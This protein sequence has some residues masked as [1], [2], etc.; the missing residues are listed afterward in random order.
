MARLADLILR[1]GYYDKEQPGIYT[2][3]LCADIR[4]AAD[5]GMVIV[6]D[7][8]ADLLYAD[9]QRQIHFPDDFPT[10]APPAPVLWIEAKSSVE[11]VPITDGVLIQAED[12]NPLQRNYLADKDEIGALG[13]RWSLVLSGFKLHD[14]HA[15]LKIVMQMLI[16]GHGQIVGRLYVPE[17][18]AG[19]E[20]ALHYGIA[21]LSPALLTIS[22]LHARNVQLAPLE[23]SEKLRKAYQRR[24][25]VEPLRFRTL[26][27]APLRQTLEREGRLGEQGLGKALHL[28]RGHFAH[29][30]EE[31]P[32]F[33]KYV[34]VFW[35]PLH[36]RGRAERGVVVGERRLDP[37]AKS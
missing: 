5:A 33:G 19:G 2:D 37:R 17:A 34:G 31:R 25:G 1:E 8:V 22:F 27:M 18:Y 35:H 30:S 7:D 13:A 9:P 24:H 20:A 23:A 6:A 32:L 3:N 26:V 21:L 4:T 12:L 28:V 15:D 29:Y 10:L 14:K 36:T 11:G 16:D